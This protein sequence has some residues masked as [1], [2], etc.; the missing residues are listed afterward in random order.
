VNVIYDKNANGGKGL[1]DKQKA[2]F[3]KGQ[4]Q[5]AKDQFG[6]ADIHLNVTY[7]AGAATTV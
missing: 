6:D 3:Q 4:L 5:N 7:T 2:D 1:T